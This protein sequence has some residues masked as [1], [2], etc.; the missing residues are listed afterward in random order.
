VS[1]NEQPVRRSGEGF[2]LD[3][4]FYPWHVSDIGKDLMLIDRF[5]GLPLAEF[6]AVVDDTFDRGRA[7]ILLTLIAT[8]IR[9][10]HPDWSVERI[11]RLVMDLNLGELTFVDGDEEE[12]EP[13]PPPET[14]ERPTGRS[15]ASPSRSPRSAP[16]LAASVTSSATPD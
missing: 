2:E 5:S 8:S 15:S 3:G 4:E 6:Y 14:E 9:A 16:E 13:G 12:P 11:I 10:K 1:E 7:P